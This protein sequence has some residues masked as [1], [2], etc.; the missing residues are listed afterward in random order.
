PTP[1]PTTHI[2]TLSLHDALPISPP[3]PVTGTVN[4]DSTVLDIKGD[5]YWR[6]SD[7]FTVTVHYFG[8]FGNAEHVLPVQIDN[9]GYRAPNINFANRGSWDHIFRPNLINTFNFGYNDILSV[10]NCVDQ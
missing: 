5:T 1:T 10:E 6:D 8:S 7:H 4:A 3:T 2:S 9:N